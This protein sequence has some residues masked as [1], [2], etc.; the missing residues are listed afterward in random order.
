MSLKT[1]KSM[2]VENY[3]V[4]QQS[5]NGTQFG[6][7][8]KC[9]FRVPAH[10]GYVDF[11]TSYME[12]DFE[13]KGSRGKMEFSNDMSADILIR[14]WRV[15]I[16]GH[17][18]EEI[19]HPNILCK[20]LKYD[21]GMDLGNEELDQVF[22]KGGIS[23]AYQGFNKRA[24]TTITGDTLNN[25]T[26]NPCEKIKCVLDLKFSGVFGSTQ[27]FP[28]G[29]TGDVEIE[30]VW[31]EARRCL[32][33]TQGADH[34]QR[35]ASSD[36]T[37]TGT[38]ARVKGFAV[39]N[40][41][42]GGGA[43]A[44]VLLQDAQG[45]DGYYFPN[46]NEAYGVD[47]SAGVLRCEGVPFSIGQALTLTGTRADNGQLYSAV[48]TGNIT[49]ITGNDGGNA[50]KIV[51]SVAFADPTTNLT[52]CAIHLTDNVNV[53]GNL[54]GWDNNNTLT[55]EIS[56]PTLAL[57]VVAPPPQYVAEQSA[58][59]NAEGMAIDIP[60]YT[61]YKANTY[62]GV[63]SATIEI[64]CYGSRAKSVLCIGIPQQPLGGKNL[65]QLPYQMRGDYNSL[66]QYQ[67]QIGE[68]REPVR[69]VVCSNLDTYS[70]NVAQEQLTE[71]EKALNSAGGK[72]NSLRK[73]KENFIIGRA[74][75]KYGGSVSL[76][77]KGLRLYLDYLSTTT[78]AQSDGSNAVVV[79]NKNWY[80]F[81]HHIR[82]MNITAQGVSVMY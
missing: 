70:E 24:I 80:N 55:Y 33:Y 46:V 50:G 13:V 11:H 3:S 28:V 79:R 37:A 20:A 71:L 18:I 42:G 68:L 44:E 40:I 15:L 63:S 19:D 43:I 9:R 39:E 49:A 12:F 53:A 52:N 69:P 41:T 57:Q 10:L 27:T 81:V 4:V 29:M 2:P 54:G 31:E 38:P 73:H 30:I 5:E 6:P 77:M 72:V 59:V 74:L 35:V 82:R 58:K 26:L 75:S 21:Y 36:G 66:N 22:S 64:P 25:S 14:S 76:A 47:N 32:Q 23:Q 48:S 1:S 67:F 7:M 56:V 45:L 60:T 17:I 78:R 16:G 62:A 8:N 61:C 51:I 34:P 65:V